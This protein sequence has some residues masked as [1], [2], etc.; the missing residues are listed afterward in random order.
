MNERQPDAFS[1]FLRW[2]E[3]R[4]AFLVLLLLS[5][6][7]KVYLY[8]HLDVISKDSVLYITAAHYLQQGDPRQALSV[9]PLPAFSLVLAF[10][11]SFL[12]GWKWAGFPVSV[13]ASVVTL[14]PIYWTTRELFNRQAAFW[15]AMAFALS[16]Y[17]NHYGVYVIRDPLYLMVFA[18]SLFYAVR[19]LHER[20]CSQLGAALLLNLAAISLRVEAVLFWP[21][22]GGLIA[23]SWI[24]ER[25]RKPWLPALACWTLVPL[26]L[27]L[28]VRIAFPSGWL[29]LTQGEF[30]A[31]KIKALL[32]GDFLTT[33]MHLNKDLE[34]LNISGG[35]RVGGHNLIDTVRHYMPLIYALGV[36]ESFLRMLYP[37]YGIPLLAGLR[38]KPDR[39]R[40][41]LLLTALVFF[42][43]SYL[44]LIS[45]NWISKRYLSVCVLCLVPWVGNGIDRLVALSRR[46]ARPRLAA[47]VLAAAF[48]L[49]PTVQAVT[50]HRR[51][52]DDTLERVGAWIAAN[53]VWERAKVFATDSRILFYAHRFED[54]P[55]W[56]SARTRILKSLRP[57]SRQE[58]VFIEPGDGPGRQ[59]FPGWN[60]YTLIKTFHGRRHLVAVYRAK[61]LKP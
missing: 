60:H 47:A 13:V 52:K 50:Q 27:L 21:V 16:P 2:T 30:I 59:N 29:Y 54:I 37:L 15:A 4:Q 19:F 1:R 22:V 55:R 36:T 35:Y 6:M 44:F 5:A 53:P 14:V 3:S 8:F 51:Q 9:Y 56:G 31:G 12:P 40:N 46:A 57:S 34:S 10:F 26:A 38:E 45:E 39:R 20:R 11:H 61:D 23:F 42:A 48:L 7:I 58:L 17:L 18:W 41:V 32:S 28:L 33:Y 43:A 25:N 24:A 49:T